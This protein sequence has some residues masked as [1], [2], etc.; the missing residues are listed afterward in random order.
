MTFYEMIKMIHEGE[1]RPF[2]RQK[3]E[4]GRTKSYYEKVLDSLDCEQVMLTSADI[5]ATDWEVCE[6]G[7]SDF[8]DSAFKVER[9]YS[10]DFD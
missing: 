8:T 3:T 6:K 9:S 2:G 10:H 7:V 5:F 1:T 4:L